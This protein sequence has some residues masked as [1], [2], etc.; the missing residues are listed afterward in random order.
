V[1]SAGEAVLVVVYRAGGSGREFL[2]A[3][4]APGARSTSY[5]S[6]ISG[7]VEVGE[8][9]LEAARRE[10][11]EETGL[12]SPLS[13]DAFPM[14][15]GFHGDEGWVVL[16]VFSASASAGWEPTLDDEHVDYRWCDAEEALRVLFYEEPRAAL[17][18]VAGLEG[19][20]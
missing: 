16:H 12:A 1:S 10:L 14:S 6:L 9:P 5:W 18:A 15:L 13:W 11:E 3:L 17:R 20:A 2:V 8:T 19:G 4:R 7:G